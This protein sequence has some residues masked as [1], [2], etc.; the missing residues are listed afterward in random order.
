MNWP[1]R[2]S[3][4]CRHEAPQGCRACTGCDHECHHVTA[5]QAGGGAGLRELYEQLT[6]S[7]G[8]QKP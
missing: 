5:D 6:E 2:L 8:E 1:P 4:A 3:G 7:E